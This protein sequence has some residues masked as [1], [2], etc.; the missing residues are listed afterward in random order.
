M[1]FHLLFICQLILV[2]SCNNKKDKTIITSVVKKELNSNSV[3]SSSYKKTYLSRT[4]DKIVIINH[5]K[6]NSGTSSKV[7]DSIITTDP[8]ILMSFDT[9]LSKVKSN[10]Q[11]MNEEYSKTI[12]YYSEDKLIIKLRLIDD[13]TKL[14]NKNIGIY[15]ENMQYSYSIEPQKWNKLYLQAKNNK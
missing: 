14:L 11:Y 10:K 5:K 7:L 9:L 8:L 12:K 1:R 15:S 13:T 6:T 4:I 3:D 2:A